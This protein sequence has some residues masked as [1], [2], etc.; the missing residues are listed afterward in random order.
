MKPNRL[1]ETAVCLSVFLLGN[2]VHGIIKS[3]EEETGY[4]IK[5]TNLSFIASG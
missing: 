4:E 3:L 5:N 2:S 1:N